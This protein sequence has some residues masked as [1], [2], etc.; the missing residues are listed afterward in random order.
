[1]KKLVIIA[2][3]ILV[4]AVGYKVVIPALNKTECGTEHLKT[5]NNEVNLRDRQFA[6]LALKHRFGK[7]LKRNGK[8]LTSASN[9]TVFKTSKKRP[10]MS[11][12][13]TT[14][15][16]KAAAKRAHR[17]LSRKWKSTKT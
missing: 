6:K 13:T 2:A 16:S 9:T 3:V 11:V 15:K 1:M 7:S 14:Y 8:N 17:D 5:V 12:F 4:A 10:W